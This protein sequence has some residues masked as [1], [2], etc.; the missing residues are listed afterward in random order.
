MKN[1][2]QSV[3]TILLLSFLILGILGNLTT[4]A[5]ASAS[6]DN[7]EKVLVCVE[8]KKGDTL[9]SIAKQYYTDEFQGIGAYIKEIK[10]SNGLMNDTIHTGQYL[11]VPFYRTPES[12]G[13]L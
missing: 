9:W 13:I 4:R 2:K 1:T 10:K 12:L 11:I 3:I 6:V 8:I 5:F 7:K